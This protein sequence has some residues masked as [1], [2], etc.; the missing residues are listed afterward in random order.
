MNNQMDQAI[1]NEPARQDPL[2]PWIGEI[3][4]ATRNSSGWIIETGLILL[5]AKEQLAHGQWLSMW[6]TRRM[7]FGVRTAEMLMKVARHP[8][9]RD[10]KSISS[11]P[12]SWSILYVLSQL[13]ANLVQQEI[14]DGTIN[15]ELKLAEA[16]HLLS[17]SRAGASAGSVTSSPPPFNVTR[18]KS[19]FLQSLGRRCARWPAEHRE[20]LA[21]T[22]ETVAA[23][24]RQGGNKS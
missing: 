19:R 8:I 23:Q 18:Q 21:Q 16:R 10:P 24:L 6:E 3:N 1:L 13:P 2:E 11:L 5:R 7:P 22:L 9:L 4:E 14:I 17:Q 20:E 12:V 15:P